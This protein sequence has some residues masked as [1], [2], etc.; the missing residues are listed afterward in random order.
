MPDHR[1]VK[2]PIFSMSG[3]AL[4]NIANMYILVILIDF[5]FCMHNFVLKSYTYGIWKDICTSRIGVLFDT[6]PVERRTL[7]AGAVPP[8][9]KLIYER[10]SVSQSLLVRRS[11]LEPMTGY[12]FSVWQL[13][14][15]WCWTPSLTRRWV[16]NLLA[17]LLLGLARAVTLGSKSRITR[18]HTSLFHLRLLQPGEPDHCINIPQDQCGPIILPG[19]GFPFRRLLRLAG[20]RWRYSNPPPHGNEL[21]LKSKSKLR[22][23]FSLHNSEKD[24]V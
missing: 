19:T 23:V 8:K 15:S 18:N 13:R 1:Q 22:V 2:C 10:R 11:H 5:G 21:K 3:F 17:Q 12:L 14:V 24:Q 9:L 20:L 6:L 7:F 4:S 16:C